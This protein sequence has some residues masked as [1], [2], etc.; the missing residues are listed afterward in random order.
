MCMLSKVDFETCKLNSDPHN[1]HSIINFIIANI[2]LPCNRFWQV[3]N[4][5]LD[6]NFPFSHVLNSI[7]GLYSMFLWDAVAIS[8]WIDLWQLPSWMPWMLQDS[9]CDCKMPVSFSFL[10]SKTLIK[11]CHYPP[12]TSSPYPTSLH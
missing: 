12:W 11:T 7:R 2:G 9:A 5:W 4:I 6:D 1:H 8:H 10:L 3:P